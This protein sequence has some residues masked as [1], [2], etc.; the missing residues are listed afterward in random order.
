MDTIKYIITV[1]LHFQEKDT[2]VTSTE[3]SFSLDKIFRF[4]MYTLVSI[5]PFHVYASL[6]FL[7]H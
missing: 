1:I 3:R 4:R 6:S 5:Q 2:N 7:F